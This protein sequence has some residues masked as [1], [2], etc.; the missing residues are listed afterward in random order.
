MPPMYLKMMPAELRSVQPSL[1]K[2][3][4]ATAVA[5]SLWF[6][7]YWQLMPL[8]EWMTGQLGLVRGTH[9]EEA[10]RFF[11]YDTPKVLMLLIL[12]VFAMGVV[13]TYF[14]PERTR[15]LLAGRSSWDSS[16]L[17]CRSASP[18]PS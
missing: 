9:L 4:V 6:V 7:A 17:A 12:V 1:S 16:P 5:T 11:A 15:A 2:W 3:L 10:V 8:S 14:S 18:S 13:R